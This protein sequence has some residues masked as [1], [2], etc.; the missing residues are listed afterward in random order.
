M[1]DRLLD[2]FTTWFCSKGGVWQTTFFTIAIVIAELSDRRLD[3]H[4]FT[5]LAVLTVYSAITQPALAYS[6]DRSAK[7]LAKL[8]A[9]Q[10]E[11]LRHLEELLARPSL[12]DK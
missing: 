3:P 6:G 8:E 11:Q 10:L 9:Q 12:D 2:R 5:L 4:A 1:A 7:Q